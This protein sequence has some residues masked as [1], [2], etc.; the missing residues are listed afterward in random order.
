MFAQSREPSCYTN[1][2]PSRILPGG[3]GECLPI[4][5]PS[6]PQERTNPPVSSVREEKDAAATVSTAQMED[7]TVATVSQVPNKKRLERTG[8]PTQG[9]QGP[10]EGIQ[11]RTKAT[12]Q[13]G[14]PDRRAPRDQGWRTRKRS[15]NRRRRPK[16]NDLAEPGTLKVVDGVICLMTSKIYNVLGSIATEGKAFEPRT[17]TV[18]TCSGYNLV[19]KADLPPD[20]TRLVVRD[21][22]RQRLA[23]ANNDPLKLSAVVPLAVRLRNTTF[24]IPFIFADQLAVPVFLGTAFIDT[25]VRCIDI[26]AERLEALS[27]WLRCHR[28]WEKGADSPNQAAQASDKSG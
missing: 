4:I 11:P 19:R 1:L 5:F 9:S 16:W 10:R 14:V 24:R 27:R 25:H 28:R 7:G 12:G 20:W 22:P 21:A 23:G 26:E 3:G 18:G 17:I 6:T 13:G 15:R 2:D 8:G